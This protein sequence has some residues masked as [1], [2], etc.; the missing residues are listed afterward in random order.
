[1]KSFT[2]V[3]FSLILLGGVL[4]TSCNQTNVVDILNSLLKIEKWSF[5]D[6][7]TW[8]KTNTLEVLN[9]NNLLLRDSMNTV[10]EDNVDEKL[11]QTSLL[12]SYEYAKT[13]HW[14]ADMLT[15]MNYD[16]CVKND[17]ESIEIQKEFMRIFKSTLTKAKM[18][19]TRFLSALQFIDDL[20]LSVEKKKIYDLIEILSRFNEIEINTELN[21]DRFY[22]LYVNIDDMLKSIINH[23]VNYLDRFHNDD[24]DDNDPL[25]WDSKV[26][27]LENTYRIHSIKNFCYVKNEISKKFLRKNTTPIDFLLKHITKSVDDIIKINYTDLGFEYDKMTKTSFYNL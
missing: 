2:I 27:K 3:T 17:E 23:T 24:D 9:I 6:K 22:I 11:L 8:Y 26:E 5:S 12:I 18:V 10:N 25:D 21:D 1:M 16:C 13:I 15:F 14:L 20:K 19:T 4:L 7:Y